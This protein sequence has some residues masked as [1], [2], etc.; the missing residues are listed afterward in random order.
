MS[1]AE[2]HN[3]DASPPSAGHEAALTQL[4]EH[5]QDW[6]TFATGALRMFQVLKAQMAAVTQETERAATELIIHLRVLASSDETAASGD[7]AASVAK[8]VMAMQF[9]D[10][11][12]QTLEHVGLHLDQLSRH[13]QALLK[14]PGNEEVRKEIAALQVVEQVSTMED[15]RRLYREVFQ[16]DYEEP[17]PTDLLDEADSVTLF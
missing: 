15:E 8:A 4:Q 9:Q 14:G 1:S 3:G 7:R 10:I 13:L 16:P 5:Q 6:E 11:T 2:G 17:V 12:R